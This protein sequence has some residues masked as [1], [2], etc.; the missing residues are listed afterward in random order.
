MVINDCAAPLAHSSICSAA[1]CCSRSMGANFIELT[2]FS[3]LWH[4][5]LKKKKNLLWPF[6]KGQQAE[7]EQ[8][9]GFVWWILIFIMMFHTSGFK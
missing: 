4:F 6:C 3:Y 7:G 1:L 8:G 9:G 2:Y 5:M